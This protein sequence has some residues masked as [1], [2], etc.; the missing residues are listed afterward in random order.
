MTT[1]ERLRCSVHLLER[2]DARRRSTGDRGMFTGVERQIIQ[3]ELAK[4]EAERAG[5][6]EENRVLLSPKVSRGEE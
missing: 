1:T 6:L 4:L 2:I 5:G 3:Q